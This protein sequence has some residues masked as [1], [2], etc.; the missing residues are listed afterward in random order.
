MLVPTQHSFAALG[1]VGRTPMEAVALC[2]SR[3]G[4]TLMS[5][6]GR[7]GPDSNSVMV[8]PA[9]RR[10][11]GWSIML[12]KRRSWPEDA[13]SRLARLANDQVVLREVQATVVW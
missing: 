13:A 6:A 1:R 5:I 4:Q 9:D 8:V 2:Q 12:V 10:S 11:V 7:S 3:V